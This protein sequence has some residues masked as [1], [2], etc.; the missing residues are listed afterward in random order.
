MKSVFFV[1]LL[2]LT[3][4]GPLLDN[5][6]IQGNWKVVKA[7][8]TDQITL[9]PEASRQFEPFLAAFENSVFE[10]RKN[11]KSTFKTRIPQFQ[12]ED[13]LWTVTEDGSYIEIRDTP[14][15]A[16]RL[17]IAM[18]ETEEESLFYIMD[19]PFVLTVEKL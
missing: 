14:N 4:P 7:E 19:T 6:N 11:G 1:W 15:T 16:P 3:I 13:L 9:E 8:L 2:I 10:F 12:Y 5:R 18:A 17:V